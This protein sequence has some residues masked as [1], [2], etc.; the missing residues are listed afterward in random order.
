M[1]VCSGQGARWCYFVVCF[2]ENLQWVCDALCSGGCPVSV[3]AVHIYESRALTEQWQFRCWLWWSLFIVV[4]VK[5][6]ANSH[7]Q[8]G[9]DVQHGVP[10][11]LPYITA[12]LSSLQALLSNITANFS[13]VHSEYAGMRAWLLHIAAKFSAI[14]TWLSYVCTRFSDVQAWLSNI[15]AKFFS[16]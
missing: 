2:S 16:L 15:A 9:D 8:D 5:T 7:S 4:T 14:H 11:Q 6:S 13:D 3:L 12:M 1:I 10:A